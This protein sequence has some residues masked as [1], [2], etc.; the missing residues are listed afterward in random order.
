[1]ISGET[2]EQFLP[3]SVYEYQPV[4][5]IDQNPDPKFHKVLFLS[6]HLVYL[7]EVPVFYAHAQIQAVIVMSVG[8]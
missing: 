8:A 7:M 5:W 6:R 2:R 4:P 3:R 1:M